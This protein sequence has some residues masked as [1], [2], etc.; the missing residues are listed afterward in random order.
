MQL[1]PRPLAAA[2]AVVLAGG[3]ATSCRE[4][5]LPEF[6]AAPPTTTTAPT[7]TTPP[8]T[9]PPTST[10]TSN[11]TTTATTTTT[12]A[13]TS[14]A[15]TTT[16]PPLTS[17]PPVTTKPPVTTTD[18]PR[19]G[20]PVGS[21]LLFNGDFNTGDLSQY[22]NVQAEG[23]N[24]N[25]D[26]VCEGADG[27]VCVVNGGPGHETAARFELRP[28]D[29]AAGGERAELRVG[30]EGETAPGDERW[31][32][33]DLMFEDFPPPT[34]RNSGGHMIVMQW[35]TGSG[36]PLLTLNVDAA[37]NFTIG[38]RWDNPD[39]I[40][41]IDE[42]VWHSYVVHVRFSRGGDGLIEVYRDGVKVATRNQATH[43]DN[44]NYLKLGIY[45][46]GEDF[47]Q[48][49]LYDGLRITAP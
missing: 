40:G 27:R 30:D 2:V 28:G 49:L 15:T 21:R 6:S 11:S 43:K 45:R 8:V 16:R 34:G 29:E 42:G 39:I 13:A 4:V 5:P 3:L 26:G 14:S 36:S 25:P 37:G 32:S 9:T 31:Y 35:H 7:T 38:E 20:V 33:F 23:V 22:A 24:S 47:T 19:K 46:G 12:T 10:S 48:S 44:D 1:S 17:I 18:P 41:P